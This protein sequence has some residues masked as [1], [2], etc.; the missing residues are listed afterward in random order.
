[1][2]DKHLETFIIIAEEGSF[3]KAAERLYVSPTALI[4]QMN[5]LEEEVGALLLDRSPKGITLTKAGEYF[6]DEAKKILSEEKVLLE[7]TRKLGQAKEEAIRV[8]I[9]LMNQPSLLLSLWQKKSHLLPNYKLEMVPYDDN[10]KE[11][12][13]VLDN[14]GKNIDLVPATGNT[15]DFLSHVQSVPIGQIKASISV[16]LTHKLASRREIILDD[17]KDETI[18][19]PIPGYLT[20]MDEIREYLNSLDL[21][22]R[23]RYVQLYSYDVFNMAASENLPMLVPSNW[24]SA[25]PMLKNVDVD[26]DF[27]FACN[28]YTSK[29]PSEK[30]RKFVDAITSK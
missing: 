23:Y 28:L 5:L 29:A 6:K 30:I 11:W 4:K 17:L 7:E 20:E 3:L 14:L 24:T 15:P 18:I 10:V 16:P 8:G 25:H 27:Y 1:M 26:W 21:G 9:S 22:I 13:F 19:I 12:Y 2:N